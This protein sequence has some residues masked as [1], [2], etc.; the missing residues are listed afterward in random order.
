MNRAPKHGP[1]ELTAL[2]LAAATVV[3]VIF[4]IL[5]RYYFYLALALF[6][7]FVL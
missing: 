6:S 1:E 3:L 2:R 4:F 5:T 7:S